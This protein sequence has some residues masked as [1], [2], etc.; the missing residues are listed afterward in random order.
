MV[1]II[2]YV[3]VASRGTDAFMAIVA[4]VDK[5]IV[6]SNLRAGSRKEGTQGTG[7]EKNVRGCV[8]QISDPMNSIGIEHFGHKKFSRCTWYK[9][10]FGKETNFAR[11]FLRKNPPE[12]RGCTSKVAWNLARKLA[13]LNRTEARSLLVCSGT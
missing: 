9:I 12:E 10:E 6:R 2:P 3:V 5:L 13:K 11:P 7:R 4:H 1:D 8:S